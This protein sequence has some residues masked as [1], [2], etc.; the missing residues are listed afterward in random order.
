MQVP[1]VRAKG[2]L[3]GVPPTEGQSGKLRSFENHQMDVFR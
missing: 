3:S 2:S 1:K